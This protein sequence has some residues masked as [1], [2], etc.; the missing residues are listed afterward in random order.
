[1]IDSKISCSWIWI[2]L[3][4][5][6]AFTFKV[7]GIIVIGCLRGMILASNDALLL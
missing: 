4:L 7:I 1:M 5:F 2:L 6:L 3:R